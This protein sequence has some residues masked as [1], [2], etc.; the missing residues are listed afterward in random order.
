[1][2]KKTLILTLSSLAVLGA[3]VGTY[4][5][6]KRRKIRN[7]SNNDKLKLVHK[8]LQE[9]KD[10]GVSPIWDTKK[11]Y[12]GEVLFRENK[13]KISTDD[14]FFLVNKYIIDFEKGSAYQTKDYES[15]TQGYTPHIVINS[16]RNFPDK[17]LIGFD[18]LENGGV[19]DKWLS[20]N[21]FIDLGLNT[22]ITIIFYKKW[23][24]RWVA[25]NGLFTSSTGYSNSNKNDEL[26]RKKFSGR[27]SAVAL[28]KVLEYLC[29]GKMYKDYEK[30]NI[31]LNIPEDSDY[32]DDFCQKLK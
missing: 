8:S 6:L 12:D 21:G 24:R 5:L 3:G 29:S 19:T 25:E 30:Y 26:F 11:F 23:Q 2:N 18:T 9:H 10:F 4:L 27:N 14:E 32:L 16:N 15:A 17:L 7:L 22:T 20:F 1:M 31:K 13:G 28:K